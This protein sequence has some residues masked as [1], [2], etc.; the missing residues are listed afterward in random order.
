MKCDY[1]C[2]VCCND[3]FRIF[4]RLPVTK[5]AVAGAEIL[6]LPGVASPGAKGIYGG[7]GLAGLDSEAVRRWVAEA[8]RTVRHIPP[9]VLVPAVSFISNSVSSPMTQTPNMHLL[10]NNN[11][12]EAMSGGQPIHNQ[13]HQQH[14]QHHLGVQQQQQKQSSPTNNNTIEGW[15]S[16][17]SGGLHQWWSPPGVQ[18]QDQLPATPVPAMMRVRS[19]SR[20]R[21]RSR[22]Q[23]QP[24]Q[25][26]D[27]SVGSL[28]QQRAVHLQA[29]AHVAAQAA[30]RMMHERLQGRA[31]IRNNNNNGR[32]SQK[33]PS[34]CSGSS[35][36]S[37]RSYS[38]SERS[39]SGSEDEGVSTGGSPTGP[40]R[41]AENGETLLPC[42]NNIHLRRSPALDRFRTCWNLVS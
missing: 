14:P 33:I 1:R 27:F 16:S 11:L 34:N 22:P 2:N 15:R 31:Q 29:R 7:A 25:P 26:L 32:V 6:A 9:P 24:D 8:A 20:S 4:H 42:Y 28:Q 10:D 37:R 5:L 19:R 38:P 18:L 12:A 23:E 30:V 3:A 40:L 35:A 39:S 41:G 36:L 13:Q 21:S 17:Q